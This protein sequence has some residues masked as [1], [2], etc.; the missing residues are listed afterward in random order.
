MPK[1]NWTILSTR[2]LDET[3]IAEAAQKNVQVDCIS[4]IETEPIKT[5]A[6]AESITNH[7]SKKIIAVF[8]SMNAV[9]AAAEHLFNKPEWEIYC[10]GQATQELVKNIF[11]EKSIK[12]T[13]D[14][15]LR[16]AEVII[17]NKEE[18]VVFFCGDQRREELPIKLKSHHIALQEVVVYKTTPTQRRVGNDYDGIL[19]YSPS[20]VHSF[21]SVNKPSTETIFFAIGKT[22]AEAIRQYSNNQLIIADKPGKEALIRQ[23]INHF[24]STQE[25]IRQ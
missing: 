16:L 21:F 20:A 4:F 19:F 2:P 6:V 11:G 7:S 5:E 14:D 22:T 9:E 3:L 17:Q 13:A 23:A 24:H 8:T 12:A 25:P 18:E 15:A 10:I 1:N